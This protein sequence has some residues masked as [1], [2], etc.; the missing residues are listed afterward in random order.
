MLVRIRFSKMGKVRW[1]SHRDVARIWE[2][3]IRR[4]ALPVA[5]SEGF[6]PRPKVSFG[7]ALP[8]GHESLAEYL[9]VQLAIDPQA[10]AG[11]VDL[12]TLPARLTAA[13]P[14][15]FDV[16][17][18]VVIDRSEESLQQAVTSCTWQI[19]VPGLPIGEAEERCAT[20][21]ASPSLV[22][23][24]QRKGA[25]VTDDLRPAVR[26]LTV[27]GATASGVELVAELATHPRGV[28]P[29]ELLTALRP[30]LEEGRVCRTHQWIERDGARREP[31][32]V[33]AP[34]TAAPHA[35]ARAS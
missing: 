11:H 22:V 19:E 7:L 25:E 29:S 5:Y 18:T 28:R 13:L 8:T 23:T 35:E 10:S 26:A 14:V 1:T 33:S 34:A 3:A 24:R 16:V 17:A 32:E 21:L 30:G 15:G 6:S 27:V 2:R 12:H 4:A 20:A 31:I 9:D